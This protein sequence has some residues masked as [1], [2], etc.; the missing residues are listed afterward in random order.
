MKIAVERLDT[1]ASKAP[2]F[3]PLTVLTADDVD[4]LS[5]SIQSTGLRLDAIL[6]RF[7]RAHPSN[8]IP[9][10]EFLVSGVN[11]DFGFPKRVSAIV[12]ERFNAM[13]AAVNERFTNGEYR[14]N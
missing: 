9:I 6:K 14:R 13:S 12:K 4:L 5:A 10:G 3:W 7:H 1:R 2:A 8:M 11:G